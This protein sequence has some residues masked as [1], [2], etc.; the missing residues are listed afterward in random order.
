M[1]NV[2]PQQI[3]NVYI[4]PVAKNIAVA[5]VT[6][7]VLES[8]KLQFIDEFISTTHTNVIN[9]VSSRASL[10]ICVFTC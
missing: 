1:H 8:I 7:K 2:L 9:L 3:M 5:A 10:L 4:V 6:S